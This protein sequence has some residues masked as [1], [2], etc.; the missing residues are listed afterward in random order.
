MIVDI[1]DRQTSLPISHQT[2]EE[3]VKSVISYEGEDYD[4]VGIHFVE[5]DEICRMHAQY[6]QDPSPTDCISFPLDNTESLNGE[7][8][9]LG[10]VFVC[11]QTAVEYAEAH[12][13]NPYEEVTLYVIHGLLHLMGYD[14]IEDSDRAKMREAERRHM[15]HLKRLNLWLHP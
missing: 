1:D 13:K 14:D 4:E 5:T 8:R 3:L 9:M 7:F 10:D 15:R 11:P 12:Q 6:F 2:L